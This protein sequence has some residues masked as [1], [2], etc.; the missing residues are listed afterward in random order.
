VV[1]VAFEIVE[2]AIS[3]GPI[4]G[5]SVA[6]GNGSNLEFASF[7]RLSSDLDSQAVTLET[8]YDLASLTKVLVTVPLL[9]KLIEQGRL[10]VK[11]PLLDF[12]PELKGLPLQN[13]TILELVSHT[14]GLEALSRLRF[15]NLSRQAALEKA[16]TEP[17]GG[18]REILYS[19]Q[20]FIVLSYILEKLYGARLD[21][22]ARDEL[23]APLGLGLTYHPEIAKCA[24]TEFVS[25][26][27]GL[28]LGRVH[29]E[30]TAALEGVSGHAGLFGT[31]RD[32]ALFLVHLLKG[33]VVGA[34]MLELMATEIARSENDARAFGWILRHKNW[35]GGDA[36]PSTALGH[37]GF[38]GTG[39]WFDPKTQQIHVL[40]TNRVNPSRDIPSGILE[41]RREFND[42]A[43]QTEVSSLNSR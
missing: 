13:S 10:D 21:T 15:W 37:T 43:W 26:R 18:S 36:A 22:V 30:N 27:G 4:P 23:F 34:K 9:L 19:D 42:I 28:I 39:A 2:N 29:D 5:A 3:L 32:V 11:V 40:L 12:L 20:G 14:S 25:E 38:T 31:A 8:V 24:P 6:V 41:V 1:N 33:R 17:L 16:L 35:S 7:G